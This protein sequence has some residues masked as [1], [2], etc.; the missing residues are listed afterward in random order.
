ML[1]NS[2]LLSPDSKNP[3]AT[4]MTPSDNNAD[5]I[6][7]HTVSTVDNVNKISKVKRIMNATSTTASSSTTLKKRPKDINT[8]NIK[9]NT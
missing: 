8:I 9:K 3:N 6:N 5:N 7:L 2:L 1:H 4:A